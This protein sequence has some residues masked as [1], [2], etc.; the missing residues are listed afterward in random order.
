VK[1]SY[2]GLGLVALATF[3]FKGGKRLMNLIKGKGSDLS[4]PI[5]MYGKGED[6]YAVGSPLRSLVSI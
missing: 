3:K 6:I 2:V 1:G 5:Y 4:L